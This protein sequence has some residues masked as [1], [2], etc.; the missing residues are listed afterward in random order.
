M[1]KMLKPLLIFFLY[2]LAASIFIAPILL[3]LGIIAVFLTIIKQ[4]FLEE[5]LERKVDREI[6]GIL[7]IH[8]EPKIIRFD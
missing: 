1:S 4:I 5:W 8:N 6:E 2:A 3:C 7:E